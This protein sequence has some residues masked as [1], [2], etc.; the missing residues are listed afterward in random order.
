MK[1]QIKKWG[2]SAV[3]IL[4][5]EFLNFNDLK[6]SDWVDISDIKKTKKVRSQDENSGPAS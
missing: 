1:T 6:I 2:D 4:P 3:I 5:K